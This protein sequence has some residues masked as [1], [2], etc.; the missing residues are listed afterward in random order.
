MDGTDFLVCRSKKRKYWSHKFKAPG[1]RYEIGIAIQSGDIVWVNGPFPCGEYADLTIFRG[2]LK[3]KLR[4]CQEK[5]EADRG[6]RGEPDYIELPDD[7]GGAGI[8]QVKAKQ[9]L[10]SR[11]ETCN[12]ASGSNTGEYSSVKDFITLMTAFM[13]IYSKLLQP[14]LKWIFGLNTLFLNVHIKQLRQKLQR[15]FDCVN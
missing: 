8:Q 13:E 7:H 12:T 10:R 3:N 14:S 5:I 9:R 4:Y 1:L 6:Y 2:G 11:H 15:Q